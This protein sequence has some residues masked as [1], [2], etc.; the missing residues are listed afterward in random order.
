VAQADFLVFDM[1]ERTS[2]A[3]PGTSIGVAPL[4]AFGLDESHVAQAFWKLQEVQGQML[5][6]HGSGLVAEGSVFFHHTI[7][8]TPGYVSVI[9]ANAQSVDFAFHRSGT[10]LGN[11]VMRLRDLESPLLSFRTDTWTMPGWQS[12]SLLPTE[13]GNAIASIEQVIK[14]I[15]IPQPIVRSVNLMGLAERAAAVRS[16]QPRDLEGWARSLAED[17]KDADD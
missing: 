16:R 5:G 7:V 12:A 4:S 6:S 1:S 13:F 17:V 10:V 14:H 15:E 11:T 8:A 3:A 9:T 2:G